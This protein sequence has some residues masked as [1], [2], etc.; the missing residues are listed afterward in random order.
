MGVCPVRP[1]AAFGSVT[2]VISPYRR[3]QVIVCHDSSASI[4][5]GILISDSDLR[6]L[7]VI[8]SGGL[9]RPTVLLVTYMVA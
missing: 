9:Y 4:T 3:Q 1:P 8:R 7:W 2:H 5:G 6:L